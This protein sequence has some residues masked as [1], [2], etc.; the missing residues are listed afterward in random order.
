MQCSMDWRETPLCGW[1]EHVLSGDLKSFSTWTNA[2]RIALWGQAFLI[3]SNRTQPDD[4]S[5]VQF[6]CGRS[7]RSLFELSYGGLACRA[8]PCVMALTAITSCSI[9]PISVQHSNTFRVVEFCS[10]GQEVRSPYG[11][12]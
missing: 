7:C 8:C 11:L 6:G 9:M 10:F 4:H 12:P 2:G 5:I 1:L 3:V